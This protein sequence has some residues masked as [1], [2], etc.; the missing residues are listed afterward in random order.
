MIEHP[1]WYPPG[2]VCYPPKLP[3]YLKNVYDLKPVI[4]V[5]S[6]AE[7][8]GIHDVIQAANRVSCVPGMHDPSL[9]MGLAEHLFSAQ[10]ARYRSKYSLITFPG[11]T[12]YT[13]PT[14]PAHIPVKLEPIVGTPSDEEII[15][16]QETVQSYQDLR[17]FPSM[18]DPQINVELSRHMRV[19]GERPCS[20]VPH[21]NSIPQI[22]P[23]STEGI[24]EANEESGIATNNAGIGSSVVDA[25]QMPQSTHDMD[26]RQLMER[27]N[28]LTEQLNQLLER[29]NELAEQDSQPARESST[30]SFVE[31][32]NL[33][34]ERLTQ[35]VERSHQPAERSDQLADRFS[36]LFERLNQLVE[37]SHQP[38]YR[39]N[40]LT[41][42]SNELSD[43]A[44]QLA[45]NLNKSSERSNQLAEQA[46]RSVENIGD[47]LGNINRVLVGIQHAVVRN[48]K[49]NTANAIDCLVNE[50][51]E[52]PG[53][54]Y[55]YM[56]STVRQLSEIYSN[57]S[58]YNCPVTVDGTSR[59]CCIPTS[60]LGW[61]LK[62][63]DICDD[64]RLS[65]TSNDLKDG[66]A[67]EARQ[68]LSDYLS[69]CLG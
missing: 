55:L 47:L 29:S 51:G 41:E 25:R 17:R 33:V 58:E 49:G 32:C 14:L 9:L 61:F 4:G 34:I 18:F 59:G 31:H 7:V 15:K 27:S 64:L 38:A 36:Q 57:L 30:P 23:Q 3:V 42:K 24:S 44:N 53:L 11:D 12:T 66:K 26:V 54:M 28:R 43:R 35:L 10:M 5:P 6:D 48:H 2:Q 46:N 16:V 68:R 40:E 45:E 20:P 39:A 69:S 62:F 50:R 37:K 22:S 21:P 13:P 56:R 52:L 8:I 67:D 63:Y 60:W 1:G 65:P 19:A